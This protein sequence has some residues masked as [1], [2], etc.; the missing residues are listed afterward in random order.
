MATVN[1]FRKFL[2]TGLDAAETSNQVAIFLK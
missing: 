1:L 2:N